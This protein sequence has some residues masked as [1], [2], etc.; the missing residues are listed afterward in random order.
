MIKTLTRNSRFRLSGARASILVS[1]ALA[2]LPPTFC[3][4][5]AGGDSW[6]LT[7]SLN[8]SRAEHTATLL[9]DGRV[10]AAGG[11]GS[12]GIVQSAEVYDPSTGMWSFTAPLNHERYLHT[13][14]TLQNGLILVAGG[15]G[16]TGAMASAELYD[17]VAGKW[18]STGN[19]V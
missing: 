11:F 4:A 6:T 17:P 2:L 8:D 18:T 7:G 10:L 13:A 12:A 5:G 3:R 14:T 9:P 1:C 15:V 19:L 16:I